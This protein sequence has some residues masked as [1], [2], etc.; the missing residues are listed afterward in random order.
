MRSSY[1]PFVKWSLIFLLFH[2]IFTSWHIYETNYSLREFCIK[3]IRI[4][5]MTGGEQLLGGYWFLISLCWAS[6]FSL[7]LFAILSKY[8]I[9][10]INSL[11]CAWGGVLLIAVVKSCVIINIP[12]QFGTQTI[13]ATAFY[14]SGYIYHK[15]L[16]TK[17][18]YYN[19]QQSY[20][21]LIPAIFAVFTDWSM[22][23]TFHG[24]E[25]L[26]YYLIAVFGIIGIM[27]ISQWIENKHFISKI[28]K[29]IGDKTLY[30]L[31]FHFLAFKLVSYIY[32]RQSNL[33]IDLLT[34]FPTIKDCPSYL[35]IIYTI[36]GIS[37]SL[38]I[39]KL[40]HLKKH[41]TICKQITL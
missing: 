1:Y 23:R 25:C 2:N 19:L 4:L 38:L 3:T 40:L 7:L 37:L 32:I 14:I 11:L 15:I 35:W 31:T 6:L 17:H 39:W 29:Y 21:L 41:I 36:I 13:L 20:F 33:P 26:L 12:I 9:L 28:L 18:T 27:G 34:S 10:N 24:W 8:K 22:I 5:T 16:Y 30:I